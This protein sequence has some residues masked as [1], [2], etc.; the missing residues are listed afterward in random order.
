LQ[1]RFHGIKRMG[2][3]TRDIDVAGG[4]FNLSDVS[5]RLGIAQLELLDAW[6]AKRTALANHYFQCLADDDL[7]TE[8]VLP[9]R[10][11]PGHS[12]NMF[13]VLLPL[14]AMKISRAELISAMDAIGIGIG[15]SYEA[16][17]LSTLFRRKGFKKAMFPISERIARETITLPLYP[18]MI[19]ADVER[20][21]TA[22]KKIIRTNN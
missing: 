14:N 12:W 8:E 18:S 1:L 16:V 10:H 11:N 17:H 19:S 22:L 13:T 4:K 7:L 2:D 20:V 5:A 6:C 9:P 3:G 21:S 15:V